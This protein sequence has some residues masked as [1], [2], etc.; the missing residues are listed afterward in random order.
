[1]QFRLLPYVARVA[2]LSAIYF[3]AARLGLSLDAVGGVAAAVW[4]PT[5]IALAALLLG[6]Y[7][8]WPGVAVGAFLVNVF[9]GV[10]A[11]AACGMAAGNTLE[12]LVASALLVRVV[13]FHPS[14]DRLQDV[15]GLVGLAAGSSTAISAT[16]GV[17]SGWLGGV[18]P[19]A[20]YGKAWWTWWVGD[21]MGDLVVAPLL[22]IWSERVRVR[23]SA[24]WVVECVAL[25]GCVGALSVLVF[26]SP[27]TST[28]A[29]LP[30]MLFPLL[31]WAAVRL[32]QP[33]SVTAT[34][35]VSAIAIWGTSYGLGSFAREP[36][37]ASLLELQS[38]LGIGAVTILVLAAVVTERRRAEVAEQEQRERFEVTLASIGDAVIATDTQGRV[39]FMNPVAEAVT[40][41]LRAQALGKT[42]PEV[43]PIINEHSRQVVEN[44]V[45]RVMREGTVAGLA[46]HTLLITRD[47]TE[48][49]ID[50]SGAPIR[51]REGRL[52]GV[53]LVFRDIS[54]RRRAEEM[55]ARLAAIVE[56]SEDVII[57]K[58][59]EGIIT[60]WNHGAEQTYGYTAAEVIGRSIV[61]LVPPGR[62]NDIPEILARLARGE[63]IERYETL[64]ARKDGQVIPVSLTISPIR[65]P[66][67]MI[68]G[69]ATIA[70]NITLRRQAEA[71]AERRRRE[72]ELLAELA[73]S[74]STSLDLD[75]VLQRVIAG[76]QELCQSERAFIVLREPDSEVMVG[77]YEIGAPHMGYA[78]LRIEAGKGLGGQVILTRRPWRTDN[79]ALDARF[80]KEYLAGARAEGN[81]AVLAVPILIGTRIEG[82]FY[83]SNP[84]FR[85]FTDRD[86]EMLLELATDAAFAIRNAQLYRAAQEEISRRAHVEEQLTA[87]LQEKEVL[88]KEVHHRVKNNLQIISSL[89]ELQS[90]AI[91][92]PQLLALFRDSQLRIRSMA[93]VH[94]TLYQSQDLARFDVA[95]YVE[96]LSVQLFRSYGADLQRITLQTEVDRVFLN[97]DSVIPC[98]LILNELLTNAL[99]YA[100][101]SGRTGEIQVALHADTDQRVTLVVRDTGIGFP[102]DLDFRHTN[103]LGLQLV[104][105]LASQLEGTIELAREGGT[106]FTLTFPLRAV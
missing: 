54:E 100:F 70:R 102:E 15:V 28:L 77:R 34:A 60:S 51:D 67:G 76:A 2:L 98:G 44:P 71:E 103:S 18:I 21:A 3:G 36:L 64:R 105:M 16:I 78:G 26:V 38:F 37:H 99:K 89:L 72:T 19:T 42:I 81:I 33:G 22:L 4:P 65:N 84:S 32:G 56:S 88:L 82:L 9:A 10:P 6:G 30:Y 1:M 80:S 96:T 75:T 5:G 91:H 27:L 69:A 50:D 74:L 55:Q 23:P 35:L 57:G 31:I 97:I 7:R 83:L 14:L 61:L 8:L 47:G 94:E 101:P 12:A 46:N 39:T 66:A 11:L 43:F 52:L 79:Y 95:P 104:C 86:E 48:R 49:P 73:Q 85:P 41:L 45:T 59:L 62:P 106:R 58:T 93:L 92:D 68:I 63:G 40:G 90:D 29:D 87:S 25:L 13:R 24:W 53:V 17:T 20:T